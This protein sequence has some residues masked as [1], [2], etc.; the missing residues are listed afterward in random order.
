M[1]EALLLKALW[2]VILVSGIPVLAGAISGLTISIIQA[3][4]QVQEQSISYLVK[5]S[6]VVLTLVVLG[7]FFANEISS[8]FQFSIE[9]LVILGEMP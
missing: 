6:S 5:V 8:F 4:T 9:H 7:P 1:F 3:A 2:V